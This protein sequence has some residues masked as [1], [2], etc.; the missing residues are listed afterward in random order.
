M[1]G[2]GSGETDLAVFLLNWILQGGAQ[3]GLGE[4]SGDQL[5]FEFLS[6]AQTFKAQVWKITYKLRKMCLLVYAPCAISRG[7]LFLQVREK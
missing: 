3:M 6:P 1:E 5:K 4:G 2:R 7:N